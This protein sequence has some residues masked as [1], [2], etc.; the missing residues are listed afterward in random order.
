MKKKFTDHE[1]YPEEIFSDALNIPGFDEDQFEGRIERPISRN[2]VLVLGI[3][4]LLVGGVFVSRA[5]FLQIKN[6]ETYSQMSERNRLRNI[7]IFAERG[8]IY[9]R[10][11]KELAWNTENENMNFSSRA[12]AEIPGLGHVLGYV[13][14]PKLD[15]SG[16]FW[17]TESIGMDGVE[18]YYNLL[19]SGK[20]GVKVVE[21]DVADR[22]KSE[23][24][25]DPPI[26]GENITLTIDARL[27][28]KF[29]GYIKTLSGS[30]GFTGG[31]GVIMDVNSGE[32]LALVSYPE[33]NPAV[34]SGG[35]SAR[36][37]N[38]YLKD[39]SNPFLNRPVA[40]LY[41]PGSVVK[42]FMAMAALTEDV[43]DPQ[44]KILSTGSISVPNPYDPKKPSIFKDW[45]AHGW[46]DMRRALAV[47]SDVYFYEIGGGFESQKG[48]GIANIEKYVRLFGLGTK[49]GIDLPSESEGT[50]PNPAWKAENFDGEKWL[51][52]DTYNT[53][54]GQY[55]FHVTPIQLLR[56]IAS[57]A[58]GGDLVSP[59]VANVKN[60]LLVKTNTGLDK[61]FFEITREGMRLSVTEG[62][63]AGLNIS[64]LKV[65]AKT[66]TAELGVRKNYVNSWVTGFFPYDSPRYAFIV[67]MEK[68]PVG[69]LTGGVYIMRQMLEWMQVNTPEYLK[70]F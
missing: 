26:E 53:V 31:G 28:E 8:V 66:G 10:N 44:K 36:T 18:K 6:G 5:W 62:T 69:N 22:V 51:I 54:I 43:I 3:F 68:G 63:S 70:Q 33:Y 2:V 16:N 38:S 20:N 39:K 57:V 21:T 46:V 48:L 49:T 19:L 56:A 32:V 14:L 58:N 45:K 1:I 65:A 9:D 29:Y 50:I 11:G 23:S 12:Y 40:G 60:R 55:G 42:P 17:Q 25:I 52:G 35:G 7:P 41:T 15:Q 27:E 24:T 34:L 13:S 64:G 4:F 47:S 59:H 37:I 30:V 61:K 67:V